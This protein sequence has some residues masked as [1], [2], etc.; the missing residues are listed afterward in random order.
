MCIGGA[1]SFDA[2]RGGEEM[3]IGVGGVFG[4][5]E[6]G[7]PSSAVVSGSGLGFELRKLIAAMRSEMG[8]SGRAG[9]GAEEAVGGRDGGRYWDCVR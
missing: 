8:N 6:T 9:G 4:V 7:A 3:S 5:G 2:A 1:G